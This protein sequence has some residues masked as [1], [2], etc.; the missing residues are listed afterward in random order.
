MTHPSH[1]HLLLSYEDG[2]PSGVRRKIKSFFGLCL[3]SPSKKCCL[4]MFYGYFNRLKANV[5]VLPCCK[6]HCLIADDT[7]VIRPKST[8]DPLKHDFY[9]CSD[10]LLFFRGCFFYL[11]CIKCVTNYL[12]ERILQV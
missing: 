6:Q 12:I 10:E 3:L 2:L 1:A 11:A 7:S 9:R 5:K 8:N 4:I